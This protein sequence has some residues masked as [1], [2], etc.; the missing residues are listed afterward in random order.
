MDLMSKMARFLTSW[1]QIRKNKPFD[2]SRKIGQTSG[3]KMA[4]YSI[5]NVLN[6]YT[7]TILLIIICKL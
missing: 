7:K 2:E 1:I 6:T 4:F 5:F 3:M